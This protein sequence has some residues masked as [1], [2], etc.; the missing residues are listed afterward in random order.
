MKPDTNDFFLYIFLV[1]RKLYLIL[2]YGALE[3]QQYFHGKVIYLSDPS[4]FCRSPFENRSRNPS[5][6]VG[7]HDFEDCSM[8]MSSRSS[9]LHEHSFDGKKRFYHFDLKVSS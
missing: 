1:V 2:L 7:S 6:S 5:G 8:S 9:P 3:K 4:C